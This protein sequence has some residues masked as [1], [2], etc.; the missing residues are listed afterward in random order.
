MF[1]CSE[2]IKHLENEIKQLEKESK[3]YELQKNHLEM[4]HIKC[5]IIQKRMEI[6]NMC[7][8]EC[9]RILGKKPENNPGKE[10]RA[11]SRR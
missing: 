8:R 6:T 1:S 4:Y 2:E 10:G 3:E 9:K 11:A 5:K 7:I